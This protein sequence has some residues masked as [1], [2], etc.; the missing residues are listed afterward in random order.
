MSEQM[1]IFHNLISFSLFEN[2]SFYESS[3]TVE[4]F[5]SPYY[6]ICHRPRK[7]QLETYDDWNMGIEYHR[8]A[9][10]SPLCNID[11]LTHT[12][13][14]ISMFHWNNIKQFDMYPLNNIYGDWTILISPKY[15]E[16]YLVH[17]IKVKH[18]SMVVPPS[19]VRYKPHEDP[20]S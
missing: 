9:P 19:R 17:N 3:F 13:M 4:L 18:Q 11:T 16:H 6:L 1:I 15:V 20:L 2:Y 14:T 10:C 8:S 5:W 7:Q 12:R